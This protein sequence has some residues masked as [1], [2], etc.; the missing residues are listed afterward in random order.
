MSKK[1]ARGEEGKPHIHRQTASHFSCFPEVR[2]SLAR[3]SHS[4]DTDAVVRGCQFWAISA[5]HIP[6]NYRN[7]GDASEQRFCDATRL[8]RVTCHG[9]ESI[10][11]SAR[12]D[13][14]GGGG[15]SRRERSGEIK[16][17]GK[18]VSGRGRCGKKKKS[19]RPPSLY[20]PFGPQ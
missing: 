2:C 9:A 1:D 18:T 15:E 14:L 19:H 10:S 6:G 8:R 17:L 16:L 13:A 20:I 7:N 4:A 11:N 12:N 3:P 5:T